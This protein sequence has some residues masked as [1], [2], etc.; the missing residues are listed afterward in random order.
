[1][2]GRIEVVSS[3]IEVVSGR[4]EVVSGGI[5]VMP[6]RSE[7]VS[8]RSEAMPAGL[9]LMP[10]RLGLEPRGVDI[11]GSRQH[12]SGTMQGMGRWLTLMTA[13]A[14]A[15]CTGEVRV[16]GTGSA[17]GSGGAVAGTGGSGGSAPC[18]MQ[19][20]DP[21]AG[22][23]QPTCADLD[24]MA[25]SDPKLVDDSGDGKLSPGEGAVLHVK[26]R[27]TAGKGFFAY[28]GVAVT[29]DV[30][31]VTT[32][33]P[34]WFYGILACQVDDTSAQIT[35]AS[36]VAKGTTVHLKAQVA[37]LGKSCPGA[38]AIVVPVVIQ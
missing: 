38:P 17:S 10:D 18:V 9:D 34:D 35:V 22:F 28:P 26:L 7:V 20:E 2:P 31:G 8:G 4:I 6:G 36:S 33:M 29:A 13:L 21:D 3:R 14:L 15:G 24:G 11:E 25:V 16:Q 27:E 12:G 1:M 37:M 32:S 5:E 19:P 30:P 23:Q